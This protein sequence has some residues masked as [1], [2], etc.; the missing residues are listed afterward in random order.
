MG[1]YYSGDIEGKF[2]FA[3]QSS[4]AADRFGTT[5]HDA[6]YVCYYFEEEHI[7]TLKKELKT[8]EKDF[9]VVEKFFEGRDSYSDKDVKENNISQEQLSNYA[10]YMLG[11]KILDHVEEHGEC[12]FDA[13]L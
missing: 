3:V 5:A 6:S 9:K 8:L 1:R 7:P 10:D 12:S 2:M 11:K 4:T 13:E